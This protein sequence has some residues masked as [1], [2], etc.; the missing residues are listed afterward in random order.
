MKQ[1][2]AKQNKAKQTKTNNFWCILYA[3]CNI[4]K[5]ML[6]NFSL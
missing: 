6:T 2:K 5:R 3:H 1:N 4:F